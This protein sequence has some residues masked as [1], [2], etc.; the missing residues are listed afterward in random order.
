MNKIIKEPVIPATHCMIW[1]H[2]LGAS[3]QD[4]AGLVEAL[5]LSELPLRHVCLQAPDLAV[6]IN[7]G[8]RMPAWYDI[9]G[10]EL[11][12]R[13][14][15]AGITQ[16]ASLI[17]NAIAEQETLGIPTSKIFLAGFSQGGAMALYS[18]LHCSQYLAGIV[19]LSSYLPLA[20]ECM[21]KQRKSLPMFIA[22]GLMDPVVKPEWSKMSHNILIEKGFTRMSLKDY[23][24]MHEISAAE[25]ND[26]RQWITTRVN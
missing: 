5:N 10:S 7:A 9:V 22:Y 24:M 1:M 8:M 17:S 19:A 25:V 15:K 14:D 13:E 23:P 18:A 12:D 4:M 21:A 6:T 20:N 3:N 11:T 26:L 16:S 2:G